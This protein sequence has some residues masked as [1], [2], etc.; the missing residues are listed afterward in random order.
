MWVHALDRELQHYLGGVSFEADPEAAA[1]P[2]CGG[3][4][5]ASVGRFDHISLIPAHLLWLPVASWVRVKILMV[6]CKTLQ[7]GTVLPV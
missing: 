4:A 3:Q 2:E 6:T 7:F 1:G 5:G